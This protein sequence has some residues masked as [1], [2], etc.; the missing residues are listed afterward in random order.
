M[1][2]PELEPIHAPQT[3]PQANATPLPGG[4]TDN[5]DT[6][7]AASEAALPPAV[8][9]F[10]RRNRTLPHP[11]GQLIATLH[12]VQAASGYLSLEQMT[13]VA[14][15]AQIPLA[16]VTGVATFYH[17]FR[18]APRGRHLIH[19]CLGTACY[20]KGAEP[21]A[22]RLVAELGIQFG[23]TTKD[24]LFSLESTRCLGTCGLAPVLRVDGQVHGPVTAGDTAGLLDQVTRRDKAPA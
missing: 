3:P 13:A 12:R 22:Q 9:A 10:I 8:V 18:L 24:G 15:L 21:I 7:Q 14:Q 5:W 1:S 2:H 16:E 20:V 11:E 4:G 23:E 6:I 17:F 19:V